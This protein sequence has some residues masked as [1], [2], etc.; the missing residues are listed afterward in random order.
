[1]V[2]MH[3]TLPLPRPFTG[4]A[5]PRA[6]PGSSAWGSRARTYWRKVRLSSLRRTVVGDANGRELP[7]CMRQCSLREHSPD[8]S[9]PKSRGHTHIRDKPSG[10]HL[11]KRE[12]GEAITQPAEERMLP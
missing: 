5:I 10:E 3:L 12:R 7:H 2:M 11:G 9:A 6:R 8:T 4:T 1:M